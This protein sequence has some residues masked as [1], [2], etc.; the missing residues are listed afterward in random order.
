MG[1]R[2][3][4]LLL[5]S[6]AL[7]IRRCRRRRQ[8]QQKRRFWLRQIFTEEKKQRGEWENLVHE[9]QDDREYYYRYLRMTLDRF[10]H[11]F[12]LVEPLITKQDTNYRKCIPARKRLVITLRYLG[13]SQQ[14]LSMTYRVGKSTVCS[15]VKHVCHA[16]Y[17]ALAP[18]SLRAPSTE[19][20]WKQI[21]GEFLELWNMPHVVGAIDGKHIAMDCPKT[22]GHNSTII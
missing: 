16:I 1:C 5:A 7:I 11:L 12:S 2:R 20:D 9:L 10:E 21:S 6:M 19:A 4:A 3:R 15:I 18:T 8:R 13:S 14:A 17:T 22:L